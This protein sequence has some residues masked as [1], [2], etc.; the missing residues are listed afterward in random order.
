[1][2]TL[3]SLRASSTAAPDQIR[4]YGIIAEAAVALQHI[5]ENIKFREKA[6]PGSAPKDEF[7]INA[8]RIADE[9]INDLIS[10]PVRP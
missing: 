9:L 5:A 1:M 2:N 10:F 7:V 3:D 8:L 4:L 6:D